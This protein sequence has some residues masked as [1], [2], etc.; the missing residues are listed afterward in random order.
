MGGDLNLGEEA[1]VGRDV[2]VMAGDA[3][4]ASGAMIHGSQMI[5]PGRLWLLLPLLRFSFPS[6]SSG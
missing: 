2:S 1:S 3:N 5:L 6:E 4:L